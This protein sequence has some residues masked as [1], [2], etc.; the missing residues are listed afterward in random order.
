M[1]ETDEDEYKI[2]D[3]INEIFDDED[4]VEYKEYSIELFKTKSVDKYRVNLSSLETRLFSV[5]K[6]ITNPIHWTEKVGSTD[7][8][9]TVIPDPVL[10]LPTASDKKVLTAIESIIGQYMDITGVIPSYLPVKMNQLVRVMLDRP[11]IPSSEIP[12]S[13]LQRVQKSLNKLA[14]V[15]VEK[16]YNGEE[17][18]YFRIFDRLYKP[19][20][21]TKEDRD[22]SSYHIIVLGKPFMD[23]LVSTDTSI[24]YDKDTYKSLLEYPVA[25]SIYEYMMRI[26]KKEIPNVCEI[27][28]ADFALS[29]GMDSKQK[30]YHLLNKIHAPLDILKSN[31][32]IDKWKIDQDDDKV[33]IKLLKNSS[34]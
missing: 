5:K 26:Y 22:I 8:H 34:E 24:E 7:I 21:T 25:I 18:E 2:E 23:A 29:A 20:V 11:E 30:R 4:D 28:Y 33:I 10:G 12:G 17:A 3:I 6:K 14:S 32:I 1:N 13:L 31:G 19:E 15:V 9:W 27:N 16:R